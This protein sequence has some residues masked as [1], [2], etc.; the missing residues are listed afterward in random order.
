LSNPGD[1]IV[2][3]PWNAGLYFLAE[4]RNASRFDLIIPASVLPDDLPEIE[5]AIERTPLVVYWTSRDSFVDN[6]A[7]DDRLPALHDRIVSTHRMVAAVS[8]YRFFLRTE[9]R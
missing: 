9:S 7:L 2:S 3:V 4:R 5:A 1:A 8:A 6:T